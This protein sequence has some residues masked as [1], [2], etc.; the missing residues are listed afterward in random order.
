MLAAL[1]LVG[2]CTTLA[3]IVLSLFPAADEPNKPLAVMKVVGLTA[4]MVGSGGVVF[5]LR[6]R[7]LDDIATSTR[8]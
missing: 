8:S 4:L 2:L 7:R 1:G 5:L 6:T 3:A